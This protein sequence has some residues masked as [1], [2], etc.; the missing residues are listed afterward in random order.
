MKKV[1]VMVALML[2]FGLMAAQ[3]CQG[4]FTIPVTGRDV[5]FLARRSDVTIAPAGNPPPGYVL[6]RN[7][8]AGPEAEVFPCAIPVTG[9][10]LYCFPETTGQVN[11]NVGGSGPVVGPDGGNFNVDVSSLGDVSGYKGPVGALV[12]VF[13]DFNVANGSSPP[14]TID[15]S[16]LGTA[17][18]TLAPQLGQVFFIGDGL[19]GTGSGDLQHFR[20]PEGATRLFFGI[21]DAVGY[22]GAPGGYD[23]NGGQF[24]VANICEVVPEPQYLQLGIFALVGLGTMVG[25]RRRLRKA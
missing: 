22:S 18:A 23:D 5:I 13:M 24:L 10:N 15:F 12:G 6:T 14:A 8:P 21:A 17:F 4:A 2:S 19:T 20:A 11:L 25:A 16:A 7:N 1:L 3:E 9:G